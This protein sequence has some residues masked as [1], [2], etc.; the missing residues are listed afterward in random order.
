MNI[1]A[2]DIALAGAVTPR[3]V[4]AYLAANGWTK[5]GSCHGNTGDV[6]RLREDEREAVLV[7]AS[8]KFAD[9]VTRLMQLA[10]TLG[11]VENRRQSMVLT[12]LSLAEVDLIRVR[13]PKAHDDSSIPLS[14]GVGLL[15]ELRRLLVAAACSVSGPQRMFRAGRNQKAAAYI[16]RVRLGRTEPGSFVVNMLVPV[17]PS[18]TGSEPA[19]LPLLEPFERRATRMLVSGLRASREATELV[20][21]GED[22]RAF[23]ERIGKGVSANLCQATANLISIGSGLDVSVSWALTRQPHED[24]TDERAVVAFAPSDAPVLQEAARILGDRQERYDERIEGYVSALARDQSEPEGRVTGDR[25]CAGIGQGGLQPARVHKDRPCPRQTI[26]CVARRRSVP[27]G[28]AL[29]SRESSRSDGGRERRLMSSFLL[30]RDPLLVLPLG[31][32]PCSA[33]LWL[34]WTRNQRVTRVLAASCGSRVSE[35]VPQALSNHAEVAE[36]RED[37]FLS[38]G[39]AGFGAFTALAVPSGAYT[40]AREFLAMSN[41]A[42]LRCPAVVGTNPSSNLLVGCH[43]PPNA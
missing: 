33:D 34:A 40:N 30:P 12:D 5:L 31:P 14:A 13:L 23:E 18:L 27:G 38:V 7:P 32:V 41:P 36:C 9:Y 35:E 4:H 19:Q 25:R 3:G 1:Q 10:E 26:E 43:K 28:P 42:C 20:N 16:D 8:T 24:Q 6:Y 22:I 39:R 21:R 2:T 29:A 37:C 17:S 11:R 15:D